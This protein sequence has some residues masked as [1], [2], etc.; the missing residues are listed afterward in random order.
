MIS[1]LKFFSSALILSVLTISLLFFQVDIAGA[2]TNP[3][4][5]AS[6]L[7]NLGVELLRQGNYNEAV[8]KFTE[9]I[10]IK[11]DYAAAYSN[12]CLANLQLEEYHN[13]VTDCNQA[14]KKAPTNIEAYINRGIAH[15]R[16]GNYTAAIEDNNQVLKL[17]PQDFRAYYNRGVATAALHNYRKAITDYYRALSLVSETPSY[18]RVDIYNDLGLVKFHLNDY[19]SATRNFTLAISLNPQSER[20]YF[21]RGCTCGKSGDNVGAVKD[22]S[23]T[24]RLNPSNAQAYANRGIAYHNLGYEQAAISDL[25]TAALFFGKE[26]QQTAYQRT[27]G[28]IKIVQRQI[29]PIEE[30]V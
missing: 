28:L 1:T 30:I 29:S 14:I 7:F 22:F 11:T 10:N 18:L 4:N 6:N 16:Q 19:K 3:S 21:N 24:V 15:Y 9:A 26:G 8:A 2:T 5:S 12:R 17:K 23:N 25:Q 27:L 13:A 20:A